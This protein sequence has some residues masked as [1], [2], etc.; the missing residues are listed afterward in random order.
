MKKSTSGCGSGV[1]LLCLQRCYLE[2]CGD[3][4]D[5]PTVF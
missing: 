2:M 1:L 4:Q 5:L 3:G